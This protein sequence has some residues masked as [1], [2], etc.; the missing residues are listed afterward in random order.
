M[1]WRALHNSPP[2]V[3]RLA[4]ARGSSLAQELIAEVYTINFIARSLFWLKCSLYSSLIRPWL[5]TVSLQN[6]SISFTRSSLFHPTWD[7]L[8]TS[9]EPSSITHHKTNINSLLKFIWNKSVL[10]D[11]VCLI[12]HD[13]NGFEVNTLLCSCEQDKSNLIWCKRSLSLQVCTLQITEHSCVFISNLTVTYYLI[14][15]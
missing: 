1:C 3:K 13:T 14:S 15:P 7:Q 12:E 2:K 9:S 6:P 4:T 8:P 5:E 10:P 11:A